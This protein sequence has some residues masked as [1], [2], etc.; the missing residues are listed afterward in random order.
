MKMFVVSWWRVRFASFSWEEVLP[1]GVCGMGGVA[2]SICVGYWGVPADGEGSN[3][4][5]AKEGVPGWLWGPLLAVVGEGPW[6]AE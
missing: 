4:C 5:L 3:A 2:R 1:V 6:A